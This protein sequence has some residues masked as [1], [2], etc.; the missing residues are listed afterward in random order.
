MLINVSV[1]L[2]KI[3]TSINKLGKLP[4]FVTLASLAAFCLAA[5][6]EEGGPTT[7]TPM[8]DLEFHDHV[9]GLSSAL[10]VGIPQRTRYLLFE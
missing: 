7:Y 3:V 2:S 8:V 4:G 1:P 5:T 10:V 6:A 9:P